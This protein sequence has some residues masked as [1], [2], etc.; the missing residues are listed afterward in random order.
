MDVRNCRGCGRLFNYLQGP[1]LCPACMQ[2]LEEK[3]SQVKDYLED[4]PHATIPE[5]AKDNEV[6]T[7]QIEQWI[8]EERLSFSDDSP[9]GIACE[10]CGATIRTGRYCE[11]CKNDLANRLGSMYGSRYSTVD[12]DKIRERREKARMRFLDK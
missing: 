8:R 12:T 2:K 10:V 7:R 3:F 4:N 11:R 5:I 9:I 1:H 6:S